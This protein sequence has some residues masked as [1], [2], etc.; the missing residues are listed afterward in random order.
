MLKLLISELNTTNLDKSET[1][2]DDINLSINFQQKPSSIIYFENEKNET[3]Q[4]YDFTKFCPNPEKLNKELTNEIYFKCNTLEVKPTLKSNSITFKQL[5]LLPTT[6]KLQLN[7][8]IKSNKLKINKQTLNVINTQENPS[9]Y[10]KFGA[11]I[12]KEIIS[13]YKLFLDAIG[14]K[15]P[16]RKLKTF[17]D[18]MGRVV[19]KE[20]IVEAN[21]EQYSIEFTENVFT[22]F[23]TDKMSLTPYLKT[24]IIPTSDQTVFKVY[25][26]LDTGVK[27]GRFVRTNKI[28]DEWNLWQTD[29]VLPYG[30]SFNQLYKEN[31]NDDD[32]SFTNDFGICFNN[33][34]ILSFMSPQWANGTRDLKKFQTTV[35]A[36]TVT[37]LESNQ[38]CRSDGQCQNK[39]CGYFNKDKRCC[40]TATDFTTYPNCKNLPDYTA[41]NSSE[42]CYSS[43]YCS[44][45]ICQPKKPNSM[46]CSSNIECQSGS[47]Y[48]NKC[49]TLKTYCPGWTCSTVGA[50]NGD[51]CNSGG[52]WVCVNDKW[53]AA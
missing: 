23:N 14:T 8:N 12:H 2:K 17:T 52:S 31:K 11:S 24:I 36:T 51:Y 30:W 38:L 48:L 1:D 13:D 18:N 26:Y 43:S 27:G 5:N 7:G 32:R 25:Q 21:N 50:K 20:N 29:N 40:L 46:G 45:N 33:Q 3:L 16:F 34:E 49:V 37:N 6:N 35:K 39:F 15:S 53:V 4:N 9:F 10:T 28:S 47:C 42:Q 22:D 44:S 19:G 41:C